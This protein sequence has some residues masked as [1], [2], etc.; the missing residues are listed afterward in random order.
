VGRVD[1]KVA[2]ISGAAR[3]Q[4]RS[5]ALRLAR[6]G[7]DIIALDICGQIKTVPY[8]M[9]TPADLQ[10]TVS[11]IE[12]L[13]RRIVAITAD[14]RDFDAVDEAV[15]D[16]VTELGRLDIVVANAG[17]S[18]HGQADTLSAQAW[19][20]MVDTNLTG[21]WHLTKAATP[22]LVKGGDGGSVV[23]ISSALG[24]MA[25]PNMAHYTSAKHGLVGL[26]RTLALELAPHMIRVNSVHPTAVNTEMFH[27][28][29]FY[30][31]FMPDTENPTRAQVAELFKTLNVL[32]IP[33]VEP[34]DI[35]NAIL[36]LVSD[37]ARYITGVTLPVDAG[38]LLK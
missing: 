26:M 5:H 21:A 2:L 10:E 36:F 24:M 17:I 15:R 22:H 33:W 12:A 6:E 11:Q 1:G 30:G 38:S 20:D 13:G 3:G 18:S 29:A 34:E 23:L 4:G 31:L 19:K 27:N 37:E 9:S 7:A 32:P 25:A 8:A 16:T 35:S 14:V 28:P